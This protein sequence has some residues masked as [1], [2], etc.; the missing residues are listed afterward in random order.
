[1]KARND[2]RRGKLEIAEMLATRKETRKTA[3]M[4]LGKME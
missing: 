3:S 1:M 2:F 4:N